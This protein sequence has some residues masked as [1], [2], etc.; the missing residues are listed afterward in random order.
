MDAADQQQHH[1]EQDPRQ[2][3]DPLEEAQLGIGREIADP[4][5]IDVLGGPRGAPSDVSPPEAV[6]ARRVDVVGRVGELVVVAMGGG[7]PQDAA[8][9]RGLGEEAQDEL[10]PARGLEAAVREVPVVADADE[11]HPADIEGGG[12]DQ[13]R[14]R[15]AERDHAGDGG[16]VDDPERHG[17]AVEVDLAGRAGARASHVRP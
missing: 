1:R 11:E 16:D 17:A 9:H 5:A 7:P 10:E 15:P 2:V 14:P 12:E 13:A 4:I 3:A 8:L 6:A